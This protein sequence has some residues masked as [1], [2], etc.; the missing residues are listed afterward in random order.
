MALTERPLEVGTVLVD[1]CTGEKYRV[2]SLAKA[3]ENDRAFAMFP[4]DVVHTWPAIGLAAYSLAF[5]ASSFL[6]C[7]TVKTLRPCGSTEGT[8][9]LTTVFTLLSSRAT[10]LSALAALRRGANCGARTTTA[11]WSR[12]LLRSS[13][14][15]SGRRS[16][17]SRPPCH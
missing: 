10:L 11:R 2:L 5:W 1:L 12:S 9:F 4:E 8:L 6:G 15:R 16:I 3:K 17:C 14:P 13:R 7:A